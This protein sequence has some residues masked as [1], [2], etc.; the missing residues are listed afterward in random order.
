MAV[1]TKRYGRY[2][3]AAEDAFGLVGS[4]EMR[5]T[6]FDKL[7]AGDLWVYQ[8]GIWGGRY[9]A[10]SPTVR[11]ALYTTT[12]GM[13]PT[14]RIAYTA[15]QAVSGTMTATGGGAAITLA[16]AQADNAPT[17][18][19]CK[20]AS[21]SRYAVAV[22]STGAQFGYSLKSAASITA[23]NENVYKDYSLSQPPPASFNIDAASQDGHL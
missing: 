17:N 11:L 9:T 3:T 1:V 21:G 7:T 20:L 2:V 8:I 13:E 10:T 22:L 23:N 19:A 15:S 4:G 6:V 18:T 12:T 16:V 5:A 14:T